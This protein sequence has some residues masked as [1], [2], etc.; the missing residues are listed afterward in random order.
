MKKE[1]QNIHIFGNDGGKKC[2]GDIICVCFAAAGLE[3]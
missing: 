3:W 1:I 2:D